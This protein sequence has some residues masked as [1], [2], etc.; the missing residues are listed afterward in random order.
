MDSPHLLEFVHRHETLVINIAKPNNGSDF[1]TIEPQRTSDTSAHN[2]NY[3]LYDCLTKCTASGKLV[4]SQAESVEISKSGKIYTFK[5][6]K[7]CWSDGTPVT[8][9]D[10]EDTWKYLMKPEVDC[11]NAY[12]HYII[13]NAKQAHD[14]KISIDEIG[15]RA[16]D[17]LT[18]R[19]E[20]NKPIGYFLDLVS[21]FAFAPLHSSS[22]K[23][24][25]PNPKTTYYPLISNGPF[26]L[27]H[28]TPSVELVLD[29]NPYFHGASSVALNR[30]RLNYLVNDLRVVDYFLSRSIDLMVKN[31]RILFKH[32]A[33][34]HLINQEQLLSDHLAT[35]SCCIFNCNKFPF[36]NRKLRQAFR[37][38]ID[39]PK[40]LKRLTMM[41]EEPATGLLPPIYRSPQE[42]SSFSKFDLLKA[43]ALFQEALKESKISPSKLQ[44]SLKLFYPHTEFYFNLAE[45]LVEG[46]QFIFDI[47]IDSEALSLKEMTKRMARRDYS[48]GILSWNAYFN[49][50]LSM[51]ERF[52]SKNNSKNYCQ[53]NTKE[54]SNLLKLATLA[55][56]R[57]ES[58]E[59]CRKAD[60]IITKEVP[61][62][63]I[64]HARY[65]TLIQPYI[66]NFK[67]SPLG[68]VNFD[69]IS[70]D[71]SMLMQRPFPEH[72][73]AQEL[74]EMLKQSISEPLR[75]MNWYGVNFTSPYEDYLCSM[76]H[77]DL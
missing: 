13:K 41:G 46:W 29:K 35:T 37:D 54:F 40:I 68:I 38:A 8:A 26:R 2:I 39:K 69:E 27:N 22:I 61:I 66:K 43:R 71:Q 19:V 77:P 25:I 9:R 16:I 28:W 75:K 31:F 72:P 57:E 12:L 48:M 11:P 10:F 63:P 4:L 52:R 7:N 30:I 49:H 3:A 23:G 56:T 33:I 44:Q 73:L 53:W 24:F 34:K 17:D 32:K 45:D 58:W 59:Y 76:H 60:E 47:K 50:P 15:V 67:I 55:K 5:L 14:G 6:R 21:S 64:F 74:V 36:N 42:K 65:G 70:F 20:L 62:A 1:R 18:L 51:L